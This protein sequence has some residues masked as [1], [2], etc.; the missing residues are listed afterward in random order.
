MTFER[1]E[2]TFQGEIDPSKFVQSAIMSVG[3]GNLWSC[4][5]LVICDV[6]TLTSDQLKNPIFYNDRNLCNNENTK[7]RTETL[8][9]FPPGI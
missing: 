4:H 9:S 7:V 3:E 2:L 5:L 1:H 6:K 8:V